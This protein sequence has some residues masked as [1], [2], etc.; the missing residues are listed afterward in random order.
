MTPPLMG[1]SGSCVGSVSDL[2]L[3]EEASTQE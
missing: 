3:A 1:L 2:S